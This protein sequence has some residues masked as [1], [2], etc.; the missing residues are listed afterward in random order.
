[1]IDLWFVAFNSLW[2]VGLSLLLATISWASWTATVGKTRMAAVLTQPGIRRAWAVGIA[3]F[4]AGMAVT[5]R[6]WWE[7]GLW[8]TLAAGSIACAFGAGMKKAQKKKGM[9]S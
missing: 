6:V 5:G 7:Q 1:M 3:L 9:T 2:I 4:C 8:G